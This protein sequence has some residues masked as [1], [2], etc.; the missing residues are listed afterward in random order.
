M[1]Q[2][3]PVPGDMPSTPVEVYVGGR[4]ATISYRGRS[5][6]CAGIDQIVFTVPAGVE[7]CYVPVVVK[8]GDV[9]SNFVSMSIAG[10][11]NA[12]TDL[13]GLTGT[14][15]ESAQRTGSL[16]VGGISLNRSVTKISVPGFGS[17]ESKVRHRSW[18]LLSL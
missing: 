15:L 3:A 8:T 14:Q 2:A 4:P 7:G 5:G 18:Q 10:Q 6:C 13:T 9:V 11:G 17:I 1:K 12:C 16:R